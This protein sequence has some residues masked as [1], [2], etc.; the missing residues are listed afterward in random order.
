MAHIDV[1]RIRHCCS[2]FSD[3]SLVDADARALNNILP[4]RRPHRCDHIRT[5]RA[6]RGRRPGPVAAPGLPV[7]SA[8][9]L[10]AVGGGWCGAGLPALCAGADP[11]AAPGLPVASARA[12]GAVGG[13]WCGPGLPALCAGADPVAAPG[14]PVYSARALGAFGGILCV[15]SFDS[16][17]RHTWHR[18]RGVRRF[19]RAA[20][21][22]L[23]PD[24]EAGSRFGLGVGAGCIVSGAP[25]FLFSAAPLFLGAAGRRQQWR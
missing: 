5:A 21:P 23:H 19:E 14:L 1:G 17:V 7:A 25:G 9:A 8:R 12:L 4:R 18:H 20:S 13:G 15:P 6:D 2:S 16:S 22:P 24:G 3:Q 11:V 10:G